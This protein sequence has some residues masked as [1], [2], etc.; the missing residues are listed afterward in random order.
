M[1][2]NQDTKGSPEKCKN[3]PVL[4]PKSRQKTAKK[5]AISGTKPLDDVDEETKEEQ[6]EATKNDEDPINC[7]REAVK[8][9]DAKE[10]DLE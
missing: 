7:D 4:Q 9:N 6:Q 10:T 5:L 2:D 1:D 8:V 3:S